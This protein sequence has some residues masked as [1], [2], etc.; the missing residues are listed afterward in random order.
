MVSIVIKVDSFV[1]PGGIDAVS[2]SFRMENLAESRLGVTEDVALTGLGGSLK[3]FHFGK[4]Q[5]HFHA[6]PGIKPHDP[7]VSWSITT[8]E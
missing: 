5:P 7:E 6:I 8:F 2:G 4:A 1:G 3:L